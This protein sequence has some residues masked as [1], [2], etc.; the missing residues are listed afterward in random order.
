MQNAFKD[1]NNV[2]NVRYSKRE[3]GFFVEGAA[4]Q[5]PLPCG[6]C[7]ANKEFSQSPSLHLWGIRSLHRKILGWMSGPR[8]E[9]AGNVEMVRFDFEGQHTQP[10]HTKEKIRES[11]KRLDKT[12]SLAQGEISF[13]LNVQFVQCQF[14]SQRWACRTRERERL[15]TP[16]SLVEVVLEGLP[17]YKC[18][19]II[20]CCLRCCSVRFQFHSIGVFR[21]QSMESKRK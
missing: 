5:A 4:P 16:K 15:R 17:S 13:S 12:C 11:Q 3:H 18:R 8:S 7:H 19:H 10:V 20:L 21:V 1:W 9:A 2:K 6:V 14:F